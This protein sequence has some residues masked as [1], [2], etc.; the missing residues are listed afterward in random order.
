MKKFTVL[1]GVIAILLS[2]CV[3]KIDASSEESM[4]SSIEKIIKTLDDDKKEKFE[5]SLNLIMLYGLDIEKSM[6][7][8]VAK[9]TFSNIKF[10]LDDKTADDIISEGEKIKA[11]IEKLK[12]KQAKGEIEELYQKMEQ[13][14][15][16]KLIFAK[17]EVKHARFYKKPKFLPDYYSHY[18]YYNKYY[19]NKVKSPGF[20]EEPFIEI[21]L[22]NGT[23]KAVSR[24]YFTRALVSPN[25]SI[26]WIKEDFNIEISGGLEPGEEGSWNITPSIFSDWGQVDAPADAVLKVEVTKLY[27][28]DGEKMFSENNLSEDEQER[29]EEL[30]ANYPE[31]KK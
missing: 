2:S 10:K 5:K 8:G 16:D 3:K 23:D 15:K 13:A 17:F 1:L 12:K 25:R 24:A 28:P 20:V 29:L 22:M 30:L 11:E 9:E 14:E 6:Q 26:P 7:E 19:N 18:E 21:T 4:K 31:F 27:G